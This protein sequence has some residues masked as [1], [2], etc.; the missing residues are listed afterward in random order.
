MNLSLHIKGPFD[1]PINIGRTPRVSHVSYLLDATIVQH[2]EDLDQG[3]PPPTPP[4]PRLVFA[5]VDK[6]SGE[7]TTVYKQ[8]QPGS[9]IGGF[10]LRSQADLSFAFDYS[11]AGRLDHI[12]LYR[13]GTGTC[14]ILS[15]QGG[16]FSPV[17][18]Q[19][20]PGNGI[21]GYDL[22]SAAD[23]AFAFDYD[24]SGKLDHLVFYRPGSGAIYILK[25]ISGVFSAVYAQ[26]DP[27]SG[28]GGFDL[29]SPADRIFALD[30]DSSGKQDHL[31]FYRPGTGTMWIIKQSQGVFTPVYK[32]GDPGAGIGG[33]DLRSPADRAFAFDWSSSGKLDHIALYRPGTGTFWCLLMKTAISAPYV[34]SA[35]LAKALAA[36]T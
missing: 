2:W 12:V 32:Q 9:G 5:A 27:G 31:C 25:N 16:I 10:D 29:K 21:G 36:S 19:G 26:G 6:V 28:I 1:I 7:F 14:W 34:P 11:N 3:G 15:N 33:Y 8:G 17:Y 35:T 22:R 18:K 23:R 13:P 24:S 4:P 20:D 30:Y